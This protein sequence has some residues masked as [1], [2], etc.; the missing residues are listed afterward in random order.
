MTDKAATAPVLEARLAGAA[1]LYIIAAGLFVEVAVR[2]ALITPGDAATTIANIVAAE[3][4]WRLGFV[5]ELLVLV[6]DVLVAVLLYR[7]LRPAGNTL[8]LLAAGFRLVMA[9]M[10][11]TNALNHLQPLLL[12]GG[13]GSAASSFQGELEGLAL[14]AL[15][16][17]A[18][19]YAAGLVFFGLAC[20]FAGIG[21]VRSRFLP[22]ALGALMVLAGI[23]Y[24]IN[25]LTGF[26]A[27]DLA[28]GLFPFILLPC[29]IAEL[30]LSLWLLFRGVNRPAWAAQAA[31]QPQ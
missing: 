3:P 31:E 12:L 4:L 20:V 13:A 24:L 29:L 7:V 22:R 16:L 9:A 17:H 2:G 19:T 21:I 23:C 27:P 14:Q 6:C 5:A 15:R 30:S 18:A 10:L 8:A 11:A 28:A 1:Y 26:L 25:S